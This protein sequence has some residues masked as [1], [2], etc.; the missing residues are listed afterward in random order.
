MYGF[1]FSAPVVSGPGYSNETRLVYF[2][3]LGCE[4]WGMTDARYLP[5]RG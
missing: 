3:D 1:N 2:P 5:V 4:N